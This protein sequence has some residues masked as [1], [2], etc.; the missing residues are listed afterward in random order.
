M[1][2]AAGLGDTG[3]GREPDFPEHSATILGVKE[4]HWARVRETVA[5]ASDSIDEM[6][7]AM[8]SD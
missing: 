4:T 8:E 6:L 1:A 2:H 7:G 3:S 5:E